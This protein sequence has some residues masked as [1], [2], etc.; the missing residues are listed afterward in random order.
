MERSNEKK[1]RRMIETP[2]MALILRLAIP[3]TVSMLLNSLYGFADAWFI[4]RLGTSASGAV[5]IVFSVTSLIQ[6][7]GFTLGTGA[8]SLLSRALGAKR[9]EDANGYASLAFWLSL[10]L[11]GAVTLAGLSFLGPVIRMLGATDTIFPY[12]RSYAV[13]LFCS[14]PVMCAGF[15][16]NNLLR[17]EGKAVFSM[18]G[19]VVGNL[20]NI[21]LD[22]FFIFFLNMGCAG[23]SLATLIA[24]SAGLLVLLSAYVFR[25]STVSLM[26]GHALRQFSKTGAILLTG[27]PSFFRQGLAGVASILLT[28]SARQ[29]GD[30]AVAAFSV[31]SRI[32]LLLYSFCLGI[33]QGL[34]P[35]AGYNQG[36]GEHRRVLSLYRFSLILATGVML[37]LS[38]PTGIFAP[39]IISFFR[40]DPGVVAI[41]SVILRA[42]CTVLFLHGIIA[43]TNMLLQ[44]VGRPFG[45]ALIACARQGLFFLPLIFWLPA[46]FGITGLQWTQAAADLLTFLLTL[47]FLIQIFRRQSAVP[48][49]SEAALQASRGVRP[50]QSE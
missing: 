21:L 40:P 27:L 37:A 49:K 28:R 16:L 11:G 29:W 39:H 17:A 1:Y 9:Q 20:L 6:A 34:M 44:A 18:S 10:L 35:A 25:K 45:A 31:V 23:A 30:P 42:Q 22:P 19:F 43:V 32:F 36:A 47:P 4:S 3:S 5:G 38:I 24:Q 8:G 46:A 26:P 2:V 33:G 14:A 13:Y 12:A 41:G 7:I 50:E 15:V 48:Q